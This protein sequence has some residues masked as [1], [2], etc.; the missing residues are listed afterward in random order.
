MSR[1]KQSKPRQIKRKPSP[2]LTLVRLL[3]TFVI[4]VRADCLSTCPCLFWVVRRDTKFAS[5]P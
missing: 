4:G 3:A 2:F 1:R 5:V